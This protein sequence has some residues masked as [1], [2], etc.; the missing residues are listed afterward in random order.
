MSN[1]QPSPPLLKPSLSQE[2]RELMAAIEE[3]CNAEEILML[4]PSSGQQNF[5]QLDSQSS[6]TA[7]STMDPALAATIRTQTHEAIEAANAQGE[8]Q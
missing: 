1:R 6:S 4:H 5:Q 2:M 7:Q 8:M 3:A